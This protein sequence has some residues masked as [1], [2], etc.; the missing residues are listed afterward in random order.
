MRLNIYKSNFI[1][2]V[3]FIY[4]LLFGAP[5][6]AYG[7]SQAGVQSELHLPAYITATAPRD[8][9]HICN[10]HHSSQQRQIFNP[11]S[12]ARDRTHNL[13]VPSRVRF[14]CAVTGTPKAIL[15]VVNLKSFMTPRKVSMI[16]NS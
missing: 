13:I 15:N 8:P 10:L 3:L 2:F 5:P 7:G 16:S 14:L 4:F 1:L 9:S 11:L 12:E 6:A